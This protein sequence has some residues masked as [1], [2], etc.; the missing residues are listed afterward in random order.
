MGF[1]IFSVIKKYIE[2][3]MADCCQF[4]VKAQ[5]YNKLSVYYHMRTHFFPRVDTEEV[6][7]ACNRSNV[8]SCDILLHPQKPV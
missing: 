4:A 7:T 2:R 8:M 5:H 1:S 3:L 6:H